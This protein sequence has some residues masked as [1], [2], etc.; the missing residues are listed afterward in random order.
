[1]RTSQALTR[2]Q[3]SAAFPSSKSGTV[4]GSRRD[5]TLAVLSHELRN[6][7]GSIRTAL[8]LFRLQGCEPACWAGIE[9]II[10]RQIHCMEALVR[11]M[12]DLS[13]ILYGK[14]QLDLRPVELV[15]VV[16]LAVETVSAIMR[17]RGHQ[18]EISTPPEVVT[19][20]AD[21]ERLVQI[22]TNL[23]TNAA[24]YTK[25]GGR[26]N[27]D[28]ERRNEHVLFRV[29]DSGIGIA[30]ELLPHIFDLFWQAERP[31]GT[32]GGLGIGLALVR[33]LAE[34]HGGSVEA[35]SDGQD[36]GSEFVFSI[37]IAPE[38]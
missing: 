19:L 13:R 20:L 5:E 38:G 12:L 30:P 36:K 37:P 34:L 4:A 18:L 25:P 35:R 11:N 23:L 32:Q 10:E 17:E 22:L 29:R 14:I 9:G 33:R 21:E 24:K 27:F 6:P 3:T 28:V 31:S 7:L 2:C 8:E 16:S 1:M 15:S 26:I